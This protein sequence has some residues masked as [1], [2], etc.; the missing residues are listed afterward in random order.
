MFVG[1][2]Y[3]PQIDAGG[4]TLHIRTPSGMRIE[5]TEERFAAIEKVVKKTIPGKIELILDNVGLPSINYNFAFGDGSVVG[6]NDGEMLIQLKEGDRE[7]TAVYMRRLRKDLRA[8]FPD[9]I[10]YFQPSDMI[11]QILDFGTVTSIDVQVTGRHQAQDLQ[12]SRNIVA[13]LKRVKGAVDVHLQQIVDAPEFFGVIDRE[14]A[15]EIGVNTQQIA[16]AMNVSLSGS[17]QVTPNFWSDPKTGI[18][19]QLWVQTPEYR[20]D[21]L[22]DIKTTPIYVSTSGRAIPASSRC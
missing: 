4:M 21:T 3:F 2:D 6:Y 15:S 16:S 9:T 17:F 19:Y 12:A 18:P 13:K 5:S 20:N 1:R 8:A 22:D 11:T 10:F 7:P 14:M